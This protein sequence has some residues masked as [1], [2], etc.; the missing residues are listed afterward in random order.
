MNIDGILFDLDGT[1]WDSCRVVSESWGE[2]LRTL[3]GIDNGPTAQ[4]VKGIM[5]MTAGEITQVLFS[6]YGA[7]ASEICL[8]CIHRENDYIAEHGGDLYPGVPEM[9][10]SLSESYPLFIVSNCLDGYIECFLRSSGLSPYFR[11][12]ACEGSTGLKKAGNIALI[13]ENNA[14]KAPIYIGDTIMDERSAREAGCPFIHAAYGFG[15]A[16][17]PD[18]AFSAPAELPG[19][20]AALRGG[21]DDA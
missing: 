20:I 12:W 3:Y 9:L 10:V 19:V 17:A 14:L 1:L 16:E 5:G 11:G 6:Q 15:K 4:D 7:R 21:K 13:V 2:T 18:A 8:A